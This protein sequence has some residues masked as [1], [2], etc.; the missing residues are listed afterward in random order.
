MSIASRIK[1]HQKTLT[2]DD[3]MGLIFDEYDW[4]ALQDGG[5]LKPK[6]EDANFQAD[7]KRWKG[8]NSRTPITC[9]NCSWNGH[10]KEDCWEEGGGK[11]GQGPKNW[12]SHGKRN[13]SGGENLKSGQRANMAN[14]KKDT[15]D[16]WLAT[17]EDASPASAG[18]ATSTTIE[19]YDS[20]AS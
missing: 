19:L 18:A 14:K 8:Q 4:L 17:V 2:S 13:K 7:S 20:G 3:L 10:K 5:K 16:V 11:A 9:H 12:K 15:D 1:L 6:N